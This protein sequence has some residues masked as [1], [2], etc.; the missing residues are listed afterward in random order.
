MLCLE[1]FLPSKEN[2]TERKKE[3]FFNSRIFLLN[4]LFCQIA[5]FC[6]GQIIPF[7]SQT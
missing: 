2:R 7:L 4:S 6:P 1:K 5:E 3:I